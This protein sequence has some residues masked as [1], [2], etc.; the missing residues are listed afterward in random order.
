MIGVSNIVLTQVDPMNCIIN[1]NQFSLHSISS[2]MPLFSRLDNPQ[3]NV[4]RG[5][6]EKELLPHRDS[7]RH[8]LGIIARGLSEF[9]TKK[10]HRYLIKFI[11]YLS[12]QTFPKK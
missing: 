6:N 5:K 4:S 7:G 2:I 9:F 3:E 8:C 11:S 12:P 10:I 1:L